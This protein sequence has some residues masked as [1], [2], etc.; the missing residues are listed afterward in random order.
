MLTDHS[1]L[2]WKK[3][4]RKLRYVEIGSDWIGWIMHSYFRNVGFRVEIAWNYLMPFTKPHLTTSARIDPIS[5]GKTGRMDP[6]IVKLWLQNRSWVWWWCC[7]PW[8][9]PDQWGIGSV[10]ELQKCCIKFSEKHC[11]YYLVNFLRSVWH[12]ITNRSH[13]SEEFQRPLGSTISHC[14]ALGAPRS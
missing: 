4:A 12:V 14:W 9:E 13:T 10:L 5:P 6:T 7:Y 8:N 1:F 2:T 3:C 11:K